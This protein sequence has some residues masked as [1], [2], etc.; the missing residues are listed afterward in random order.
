MKYDVNV[1]HSA[2]DDSASGAVSAVISG[3]TLVLRTIIHWERGSTNCIAGGICVKKISS[4]SIPAGGARKRKYL[5]FFD[6]FKCM[7][8]RKNLGFFADF[9]FSL[10]SKDFGDFSDTKFCLSRFW[11][12]KIQARVIRACCSF[13]DL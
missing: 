7:A 1:M 9:R 8:I 10:S 2:A 11:S 3:V 5:C 6:T 4:S 12:I 13:P